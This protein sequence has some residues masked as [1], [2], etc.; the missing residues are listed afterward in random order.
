M[1]IAGEPSG[2]LLAAELVKALRQDSDEAEEEPTSDFQPLH[3][4]LAP[5]FFGAGGPRMAEAG[6]E[7]AF[8]MTAHAVV[9]LIE[10]LKHYRTF[11]RLFDQ[12]VQ[13][14]LDRQPDAIIC[15]DYSGFNRRLAH[16]IKNDVRA[17]RNIFFNWNPKLIQ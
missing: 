16:A 12:L 7:L 6:V 1:L 8:D 2:D 11:K 5:R 10:V 4:T 17:R 3:P 14:A 13:L 9:G 15:V